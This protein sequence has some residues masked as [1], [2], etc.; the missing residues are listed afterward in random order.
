[1]K[2]DETLLFEILASISGFGVG[3][4]VSAYQNVP[5]DHFAVV[6]RSIA[7]FSSLQLRIL[8]VW[9]HTWFDAWV[10]RGERG[11]REDD[12]DEN[13]EDGMTK[14]QQRRWVG[15]RMGG[16]GEP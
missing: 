8:R 16:D 7:G 4:R 6:V 2:L 13:E 1:M 14:T 11:K 12:D 3:N 9:E 10:R 5:S 15:C